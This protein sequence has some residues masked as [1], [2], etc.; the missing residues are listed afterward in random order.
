M[1]AD[2]QFRPWER[3]PSIPSSTVSNK[4]LPFPS[5]CDR[6]S[7]SHATDIGSR[8]SSYYAPRILCLVHLV[9]SPVLPS[10]YTV[11]SWG[12]LDWVFV[13]TFRDG[14]L[15]RS[16]WPT[17]IGP[18]SIQG[19]AF[20]LS[21]TYLLSYLNTR[22][23]CPYH[24]HPL[25]LHVNTIFRPKAGVVDDPFEILQALP[26]WEVSPSC[27]PRTCCPELG[28]EYFSSIAFYGPRTSIIV[29]LGCNDFGV[30]DAVLLNL[31]FVFNMLEILPQLGVVWIVRRPRP[32][33]V[34]FRDRERIDWVLT[35]NSRSGISGYSQYMG[36]C[37]DAGAWHLVSGA[38]LRMFPQ[39][40]YR[41]QYHMPPRSE[42]AWAQT[43]IST[44]AQSNCQVDE[45]TST[46][47]ALKPRFLN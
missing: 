5:H 18:R 22:C 30:E 41:F 36:T 26:V 39:I 7:S 20:G 29:P 35:V 28:L 12:R 27:K 19:H 37:S 24:G 34:D 23:S 1:K 45:N 43:R 8:Y 42:P 16:L 32:I 33:L 11:G 13:A 17:K 3:R 21:A 40:T 10:S 6:M 46:I 47:F 25:P 44:K 15:R 9:I 31:E 38:C 2:C 14:R 4:T